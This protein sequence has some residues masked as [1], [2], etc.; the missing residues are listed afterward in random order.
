MIIIKLTCL[1]DIVF[2]QRSSKIQSFK[3]LQIPEPCIYNMNVGYILSP[4]SNLTCNLFPKADRARHWVPQFVC[5]KD[6]PPPNYK[7]IF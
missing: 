7:M 3:I 4:F 1:A 5:L 6:P 2:C